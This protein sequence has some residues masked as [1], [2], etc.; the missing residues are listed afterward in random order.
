MPT[1]RM[2]TDP[3][4]LME[5]GRAL[6]M[7]LKFPRTVAEAR[8]R[9]RVEAVLLHLDGIPV[10]RLA[11]VFPE[12]AN[13]LRSWVRA[14][15]ERGFEALQV[16]TSPG[17]VP[18]L[19]AGDMQALAGELRKQPAPGADQVRDGPSLQAHLRETRG[20]ELSVRQCQRLLAKLL[21]G[22]LRRLPAPEKEAAEPVPVRRGGG[23]PEKQPAA[24]TKP[25]ANKQGK[26]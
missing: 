23:R 24:Q 15:D 26:D 11:A 22:R 19:T 14:A 16:K 1:R 6:I 7:S 9:H 8:L 5:R 10:E 3:A 18:S 13:T 2:L 20:L 25:A 17:R 21:P 4:L 12:N